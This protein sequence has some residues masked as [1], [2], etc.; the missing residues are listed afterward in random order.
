MF[1]HELVAENDCDGDCSPFLQFLIDQS[2]N[3]ALANQLARRARDQLCL[4]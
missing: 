2:G 3:D 1:P 4:I